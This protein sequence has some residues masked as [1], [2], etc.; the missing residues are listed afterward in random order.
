MK[1][2]ILFMNNLSESS[3]NTNFTT[4]TPLTDFTLTD[5]EGSSKCI[6]Q[7][8][9]NTYNKND[10]LFELVE[11]PIQIEEMAHDERNNLIKGKKK[12]C[13]TFLNLTH[14]PCYSF[15]SSFAILP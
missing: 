9:H 13:Q 10:V 12:S 14:G 6:K 1:M 2:P 11:Y 15:E 4:P 7:L 3:T 5:G 8:I